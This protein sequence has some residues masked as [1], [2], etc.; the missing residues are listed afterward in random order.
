M[1]VLR[2]IGIQSSVR[3]VREAELGDQVARGIE[4][5]QRLA[6]R[7]EREAGK[8]GMMSVPLND[9]LLEVAGP[10][11]PHLTQGVR[12]HSLGQSR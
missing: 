12:L 1:P 11:T 7:V 4:I 3:C 5:W 8:D 6:P 9:E 10:L 2:R